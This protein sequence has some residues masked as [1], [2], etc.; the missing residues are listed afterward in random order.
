VLALCVMLL[1]LL[2]AVGSLVACGLASW[3]GTPS[4]VASIAAASMAF[5]LTWLGAPLGVAL[6]FAF[7]PRKCDAAERYATVVVGALVI[8]YRQ[9]GPLL[10]FAGVGALGAGLLYHYYPPLTA[11]IFFAALAPVVGLSAGAGFIYHS[12]ERGDGAGF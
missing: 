3:L 11:S 2:G 8:T 12:D 9:A 1:V 6:S 7:D 5:C 10:A 4:L